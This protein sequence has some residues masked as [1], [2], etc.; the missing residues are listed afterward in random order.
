MGDANKSCIVLIVL[1]AAY[2]S[3]VYY[4][5]FC[6]YCKE[7]IGLDRTLPAQRDVYMCP[8]LSLHYCHHNM[9]C[10]SSLC[11]TT[12]SAVCYMY[13]FFVLHYCQHR[14]AT[15][16]LFVLHYCQ[17]KVLCMSCLCLHYC[18][19]RVLLYV[20]LVCVALLP[21]HCA[22]VE[23]CQRSKPY[24][25]YDKSSFHFYFPIFNYFYPFSL[26]ENG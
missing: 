18:Q 16:V 10:M 3:G 11:C 21:A 14:S 8:V 24:G 25:G 20:H 26:V 17:R 23:Y 6:E 4:V 22:A 13:V 1:S 15:Y 19:R 9:L 5:M 12:A 7:F 2:L